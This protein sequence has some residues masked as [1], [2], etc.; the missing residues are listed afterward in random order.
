MTNYFTPSQQA[1]LN[2]LEQ[3]QQYG[4]LYPQMN[5]NFQPVQQKNMNVLYDLVSGYEAA[6]QY[7]IAPGKVGLL[8]DNSQ[9]EFYMKTVDKIG[10]QSIKKFAYK[11]V[12]LPANTTPGIAPDNS[13]NK[14]IEN[15]ENALSQ[16]LN[17][18]KKSETKEKTLFD[19]V[20]K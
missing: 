4:S 9:N 12:S 8:F 10:M 11:E 14:R 20:K 13:M 3:Q 18:N 16:L 6:K 19:E 1:R 15:I 5:F 2:Q 17:Q 7:P